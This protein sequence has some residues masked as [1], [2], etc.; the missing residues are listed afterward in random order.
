MV[1]SYAPLGVVFFYVHLEP[2]YQNIIQHRGGPRQGN[3]SQTYQ[4][5]QRYAVLTMGTIYI[6]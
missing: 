2:Y 3:L 5:D 6:G 1:R 4:N